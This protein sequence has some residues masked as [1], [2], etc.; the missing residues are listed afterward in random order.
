MPAHRAAPA[1]VSRTRRLTRALVGAAAAFGSAVLIALGAAGGTYAYFSSA[2]PV[3]AGT[4]TAGTAGLTI[5]G[6]ST[7][8]VGALTGALVPGSAANSATPLTIANVGDVAL[9][10]EQ[11]AATVSSTTGLSTANLVLKVIRVS[12]AAASC[13]AATVTDLSMSAVTI[14]P[15]ASIKVCVTASL[16][17]GAT[18]IVSGATANFAIPLDAEQVAP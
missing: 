4:I 5:N 12:G 6:G 14:A 13:P 17:P 18:G 10:V 1:P 7:A 8:S 15:G 16:A 9:S 2:T 11:G 3:G